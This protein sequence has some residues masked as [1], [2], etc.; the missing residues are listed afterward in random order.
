MSTAHTSLA[1]D[2]KVVEQMVAGMSDYLNSGSVY[3]KKIDHDLMYLTLGGYLIRQHQ[4]MA[5]TD[6]LD[7]SQQA[8]LRKV[9][10]DF[11]TICRTQAGA[12][13]KKA[14]QELQARLREWER[15]LRELLDDRQPSMAFYRN[16]IEKRV[17]ISALLDAIQA[18]SAL[19]KPELPNQIERL[20]RQLRSRW[21]SGSFIWPPQL[22]SA[23]PADDYW[24][25]YGQLA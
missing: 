4:L 9:V 2:L 23:Y 12:F 16:D 5:L 10:E 15:S 11:E 20:D 25:L 21:R 18:E 8:R 22:E 24:W 13:E 14:N 19:L 1:T 6:A 3:S 7:S 17:M